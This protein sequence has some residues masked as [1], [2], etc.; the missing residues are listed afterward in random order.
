[1]SREVSPTPLI[2]SR[3]SDM[4]DDFSEQVKRALA[5]RVGH[6]CSNPDC[7][8]L[9]SGPQDD[10][11]KSVNVGV[12]AHIAAASPGGPR[13]DPEM[14]PEERSASANGIWLCQ[15]HAKL[16]DNDPL[17]FTL[18][19]LLK[20]KAD[21]E[22]EARDNVGKIATT[23]G[24]KTYFSQGAIV[25]ITPIIPRDN[26]ESDFMV[27]EDADDS[28]HVEKLDSQRKI[29][30]PKSFIERTLKMSGG[31]PSL[32]QLGG[33]LQWI[34]HKRVFEPRL[35]KPETRYGVPRF[36]GDQFEARQAH[37]TFGRED[38]LPQLL[39]QGWLVFY[40]ADGCYLKWGEQVLIVRWI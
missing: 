33:R 28:L 32:I 5:N 8:A 14:L 25:R 38:R 30:I 12:A 21:A 11:A 26:E 17:R 10:P 27:L 18:E 20:W 22:A 37:G 31:K 16:I 9:T 29:E 35:E 36:I 40:A 24:S 39:N 7:R 15:N 6:R 13:Y 23:A 1:M 19:I 3:R 4:S 2:S 34:S